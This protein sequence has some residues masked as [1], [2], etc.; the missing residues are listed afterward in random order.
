MKK[1]NKNPPKSSYQKVIWECTL[2]IFTIIKWCIKTLNVNET[3]T[4]LYPHH[5]LR[6]NFHP[7]AKNRIIYIFLNLSDK[8]TKI[9][10]TGIDSYDS[11]IHMKFLDGISNHWKKE[12][13]EKSDMKMSSFISLL[14]KYIS[15]MKSIQ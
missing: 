1:F 7:K 13:T 5:K 4:I 12:E 2:D 14:C 11:S 6:K 15:H 8:D 9:D 3:I 10:N